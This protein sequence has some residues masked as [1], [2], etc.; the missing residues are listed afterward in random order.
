MRNRKGAILILLLLSL[1]TVTIL[2]GAFVNLG[3]YEQR[4]SERSKGATQAFYLSES[5]LDQGLT[6]LRSQLIPPQWTDRRRLTRN[7]QPLATGSYLTTIDPYDTNPTSQIKRFTIEGWGVDGPVATPLGIR[8]SQM[9]VQTE[10]FAQYAYFTNSE[11]SWPNGLQVYFITGDKVEGPTHTNGEFSMYGRPVFEGPVSSV[12][13]R[14]NYWGGNQVTQPVFKEAPKLGVPAKKYP[15]EFP[16]S[17]AAAARSGGTVLR[18]D[19]SVT[20]LPNGTMQVTN[21]QQRMANRVMPL[22]ENG[23]LYVDGG[24]LSI[25]GT[26]KGQLTASASADIRVMD[27]VTYATDPRVDPTSKDVLGIIAGGN[28]VVPREA[29]TNLRVDGSIMAIN[30]SFMNEGWMDRPPKGTLTVYGGIIQANRGIMGSFNGSNGT[31]LS[32]YTKDYH[33]DPRLQGMNPPFFPLTGDYKVL[34]WQEQ[35]QSS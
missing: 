33:Y 14:I 11:R 22:P 25:K 27:S 10:S 15:T 19:T 28:V 18:G 7:W 34:V 32:G 4:F 29:P 16:S 3:I 12:A 35:K 8:L 30:R 5:A 17:V 26:L 31:K 1:V 2:A 23:V 9:V 6:W 13:P 21:T 20:L 24:T